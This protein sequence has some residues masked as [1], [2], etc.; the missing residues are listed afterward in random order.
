MPV[1]AL[2]PKFTA[3]YYTPVICPSHGVGCGAGRAWRGGVTCGRTRRSRHFI[4][5]DGRGQQRR[6][7]LV[8]ATRVE[9]VTLAAAPTV[10]NNAR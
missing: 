3:M 1:F 2:L 5:R 6:R 10:K 7:L 4:V 9:V 8:E